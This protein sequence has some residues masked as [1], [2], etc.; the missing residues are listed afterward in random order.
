MQLYTDIKNYRTDDTVI[1]NETYFLIQGK[2]AIII[3]DFSCVNVDWSLL[4][5]DQEGM[6]LIEWLRIHLS[7][8]CNSANK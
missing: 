7:L 5:G 8:K 4:T 1:Y 2:I 3:D 6:R